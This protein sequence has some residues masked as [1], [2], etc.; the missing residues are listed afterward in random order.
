M[1]T[2]IYLSLYFPSISRDMTYLDLDLVQLPESPRS[3]LDYGTYVVPDDP[4]GL[5]LRCKLTGETFTFASREELKQFKYQRYMRKYL[6]TVHSVDENVGRLLDYLDANGLAGN[7]V[8]IYTSDQGFYLGEHGWFDKRFIY[9]ESFK[10]PFIVRYPRGIQAGSVNKDMVSNVDFA[11][12]FLDLAGLPQPSYMQGRSIKPL[13][14]GKT[15]GDWTDLAYHRYWMNQDG[16]HNAYAH[17]GIRTHR[18]KLIY[19]YNEDCG[20]EGARPGTDEPEWE[21]FDLGK[22]PLE[23]LNV[24]SDSEYALVVK[25]MTAKLEAKMLEIGDTPM[26]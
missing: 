21:L 20:E 14:E 2:T 16:S 13:L 8:V 9:E 7:T 11:P 19:W 17:Y 1:T 22:D 12:T 15:P 18:Y 6:Q 24:Y 23:M 3:G 10:M 26:H 5:E 4:E 25:E